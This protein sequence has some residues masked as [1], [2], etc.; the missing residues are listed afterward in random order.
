MRKLDT[1]VAR[2]SRELGGDGGLRRGNFVAAGRGSQVRQQAG[3]L[4]QHRKQPVHA[5]QTGEKCWV[6]QRDPSEI[7]AEVR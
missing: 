3:A 4:L 5:L 6:G 7:K 1:P 2:C